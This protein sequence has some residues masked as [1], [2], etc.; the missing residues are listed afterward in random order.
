[1]RIIGGTASGR[2]LKVPTGLGVRPTPDLV[3]QAI[4]NSLGDR[5]PGARVLD[6]FSGSG[7]M[8]LECLS[9]GAEW[10]LSVEKSGKHA[11]MI[12]HNIEATRLPVERHDLRV[13]D[14]FTVIRQLADAGRTFTLILA[15]PP[16]GEKNIGHRSRSLTQ[17]MLDDE[18]L[19]S[20]LEP[21]GIMVLGHTS[22]DTVTL[23]PAWEE[24]KEMRHGDSMMRFLKPARPAPPSTDPATPPPEPGVTEGSNG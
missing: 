12:R 20:L 24:L 14:A 21:G 17:R 18:R 3:R 4:F 15:D 6:L 10:V 8:G 11:A 16:F 23:T 22:R 19:P 1:M 9:R 7:A 2:T 13:A 5:T